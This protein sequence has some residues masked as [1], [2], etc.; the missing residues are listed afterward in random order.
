VAPLDVG[1]DHVTM[2][3][4]HGPHGD[5]VIQLVCGPALCGWTLQLPVDAGVRPFCRVL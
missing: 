3:L 4:R 1:I 5:A 2:A